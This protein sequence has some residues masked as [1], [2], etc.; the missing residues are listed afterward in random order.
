V[1][2]TLQ[3]VSVIGLGKLGATMAACFAAKG[4]QT[5]GM[6]SNPQNV[7]AI[8]NNIAPIAETGLQELMNSFAPGRLQAT[9]N[10]EEACLESEISFI[11]VPT[12][13]EPD[14][15][16]SLQYVLQVCDTMGNALKNKD[17][18]H[19]VVLTST[20]MPGSTGG[21]ICHMLE[22][23]SG[24]RCG[25]G[26]GLCYSPE[27]IALG[28][29][30]HDFLNPDFFL[31]GESDPRSGTM[32]ESLY[33]HLAEN[34]AP[35]ARM[36]FV[37]AEFTKLAINTFVTMKITFANMLAHLC[38]KLPGGD[39]DVVTS[40]VGMDRRI[41]KKYLKGAL[42][43]GGPCFPRDNL[44]LSM[45]ARQLGVHAPL[46]ETT[47]RMN[48]AEVPRLAA[49]IKQ[50]LPTEGRVGIL[51]LSYKP[52]TGVIEESQ[53]VLLAQ[54]L[55]NDHIPVTVYDPAAMYNSRQVLEGAVRFAES[56]EACIWQSDVVIIMTPW[57]DFRNIRPEMMVAQNTSK[58]L[59][60]CWRLLPRAQ[61]ESVVHYIALGVGHFER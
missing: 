36:N 42:G 3:K 20:V 44:A 59:I 58:V 10:L 2:N 54:A 47:D 40:A 18:F 9:L 56:I 4:M 31:I 52:E 37:N 41:G 34:N 16:F 6:D 7:E 21:P 1:Q 35:V 23:T 43:Y 19:L 24:K 13:S 17:P 26:F 15:G 50:H 49:L 57:Q 32:L 39:V 38:E 61:F 33:Q 14:G 45:L 25:E 8:R 46:A 22:Q 28:S 30:I 51:G 55:S 11:I 29:I 27:F 53:G 48:R 12:P 5:I 60:D